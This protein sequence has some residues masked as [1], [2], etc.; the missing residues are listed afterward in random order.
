MLDHFCPD[1]DELLP[2]RRLRPMLDAAGQGQP[3]QEVAQVIRDI[4]YSNPRSPLSL[5]K[6]PSSFIDKDLR[7]LPPRLLIPSSLPPNVYNVSNV[8]TIQGYKQGYNFRRCF[9]SR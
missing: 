1:L 4:R 8:Y 7:T 3:P 5:P 9:A 6:T 2:Q